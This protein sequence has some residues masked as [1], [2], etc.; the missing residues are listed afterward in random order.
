MTL[1]ADWDLPDFRRVQLPS[2][3][4]SIALASYRRIALEAGYRQ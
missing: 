3:R 2:A 1:Y 4:T